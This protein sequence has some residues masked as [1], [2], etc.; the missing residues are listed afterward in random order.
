MIRCAPLALCLGFAAMFVMSRSAILA[1]ET[2]TVGAARR[3]RA[4]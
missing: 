4:L 2:P 1:D 3:A